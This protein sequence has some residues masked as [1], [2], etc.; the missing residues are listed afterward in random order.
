MPN[1]SHASRSHQVATGQ[2]VCTEGTGVSASVVTITR[3]RWFSETDS[4]L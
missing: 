2:I 4:R 3:T 1:R